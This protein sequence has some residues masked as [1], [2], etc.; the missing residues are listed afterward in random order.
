MNEDANKLLKELEENAE[1]LL[2]FPCEFPLKVVGINTPD[3]TEQILAIVRKYDSAIDLS[4]LKERVS[5]KGNFLSLSIS[6]NMPSQEVLDAL[7]KELVDHPQTK[8]VI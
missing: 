6:V 4:K 3:F 8:F 7:Y 5:V 2:V 1:P